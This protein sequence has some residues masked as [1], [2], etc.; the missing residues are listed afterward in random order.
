MRF[1]LEQSHGDRAK[2]AVSRSSRGAG[3]A[4][5]RWRN[6]DGTAR[7]KVVAKAGTAALDG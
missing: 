1:M 5:L 6:R 4:E 2:E 3:A 7:A